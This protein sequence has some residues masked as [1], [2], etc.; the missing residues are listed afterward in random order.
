MITKPAVGWRGIARR[1]GKKADKEEMN[2]LASYRRKFDYVDVW[3]LNRNIDVKNIKMQED[4][5]QAVK[6]VTMEEFEKMLENKKVIRSSYDY[7]KLYIKPI[8]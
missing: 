2:F 7:Y 8:F 1:A 3:L 5:V 4:E 6:W